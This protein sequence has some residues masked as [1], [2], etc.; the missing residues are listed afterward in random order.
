MAKECEISALFAGKKRKGGRGA[1]RA[2]EETQTGADQEDVPAAGEAPSDS[3]SP[4]DD[5]CRRRERQGVGRRQIEECII[6]LP[7][8]QGLRRV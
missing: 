4:K 7:T 1:K 2:R 6:Q 5:R 8:G 3:A